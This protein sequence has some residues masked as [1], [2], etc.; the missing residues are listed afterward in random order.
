MKKLLLLLLI[1]PVLGFGQTASIEVTK[2]W[3][4]ENDLDNNNIVN[5]GDQIKFIISVKN[6][7]NETLTNIFYDDTF[8]DGSTPSNLLSFDPPNNPRT[9]TWIVSDRGSFEG[10]LNAGETATYHAYYT[11]TQEVYDSGEATNTVA[12]YGDIEGTDT[13]VEDVSDNGNDFDGNTSNDVTR[14]PMGV[15]H[16]NMTDII[17]NG[18]VSVENNQ[19][20]NVAD[21]THTQDV[22]TKNYVDEL[23]E[24]QQINNGKVYVFRVDYDGEA[25]SGS[26]GSITQITD[27]GFSSGT[28]NINHNVVS[29]VIFDFVDE[30]Q[31]PTT[32]I[33]YG[34]TYGE[35]GSDRYYNVG[36]Q[37]MGLGSKVKVSTNTNT[38]VGADVQTDL[39]SNYN[40]STTIL[41]L[42]AQDI[43][44]KENITFTPFREINAHAYLFF[45][46]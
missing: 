15:Q 38:I 44:A 41:N 31:P 11:V 34:Y 19:I 2:T 30:S 10:M 8:L 21:P 42:T 39:L 27:Y 16:G 9:L 33:I 7:G 13:Q 1:A 20:K 32:V 4:L 29:S 37:P 5:V 23:I 12:F 6:D 22:T 43:G 40:S 45:R 46:F 28:V 14:I 36:V 25:L 24:N 35:D 17:L 3:T 18:S 26:Q